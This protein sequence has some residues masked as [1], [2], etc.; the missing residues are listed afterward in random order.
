M[1]LPTQLRA[2]LFPIRTCFLLVLCASA[3]VYAQEAAP[4][5]N[6]PPPNI[7]FIFADDLG[8]GDLSSFGSTTIDTPHIDS[9]ARDGVR[10]TDFYSASAVCSPSRAGLLTGRYPS[11]MGIRHVF[12]ADSP[13][14]MP[15]GEITLAEQLKRAGYSTGMVGKWHLGH[16]D[17]FMPWNQGFDEFHG[18]PYSNDMGNFF[19]Y[20]NRDM[21]PAPID[22]RFLT[23]RYTQHALAFIDQHAGGPFFLYL[24]HSMPHVPLY[25]SPDF[26]GRS[27]GGLYGDVVEEMDWSTGQVLA[28]LDE[29]GIANNTL[30]IF[31]SD[32]GPWLMMR[33]QA[34]S[35]GPLRDGKG[36]TFEGGQRVPTLARWPAGIVAGREYREPASMLDWFPTFS[37]LAGVPLPRDRVIDG[38]DISGA[39]AGRAGRRE[40]GFFYLASFSSKAVA[41]REGDWKLKL[42]R[43]GYPR[44]L[45]SI[46][47]INMYSHGTLLF[48]LAEDPGE[49]KNLAGEHPERV[50]AMRQKINDFQ[51]AID[52]QAIRPLHMRGTSSDRKGYSRVLVP[53]ALTAVV[54]L[55]LVAAL[56]WALYR[57]ARAG[58]RRWRGGHQGER[59]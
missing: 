58:W 40:Q 36:V 50:R 30:V 32:N 20:H 15:P 41:Y 27:D 56:L 49:R 48:N 54:G 11:R 23:Q 26:E 17:R 42:S 33:D 59:S 47:R 25:A 35:A 34:G 21:D 7:V 16:R 13:E 43:K 28:K 6:T 51:D 38:R 14:G 10:F 1:G 19:F 12:Q 3:G 45:D 31:S 24:A 2:L 39:L 57:G 18:V 52:A 22:Q 5:A 44:F 4:T 9:L 53:L 37:R 8:Y 29:L 55:V 46:L